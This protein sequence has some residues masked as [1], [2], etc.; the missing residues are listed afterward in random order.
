MLPINA[1]YHNETFPIVQINLMFIEN[2]IFFIAEQGTSNSYNRCTLMK[3]QL[4]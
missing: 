2:E 3:L 4:L 1:L